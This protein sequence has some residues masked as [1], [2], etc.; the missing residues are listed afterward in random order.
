MKETYEWIEK[1]QGIIFD[2]DGVLIDSGNDITAAVNAL[3]EKLNLRALSKEQVISFVGNGAKKLLERSFTAAF[4]AEGKIPE[5]PA[6]YR[7]GSSYFAKLF[8][9][10]VAYYEANCVQETV[11]YPKTADLLK[12]LQEKGITLGIVSNKPLPVSLAILEKLQIAAYFSAVI[13]PEQLNRIKPDP[14]GIFLAYSYMN[15]K[16]SQEQK[17]PLVPDQIIM[18]GDSKTDILAGKAFGCYTCAVTGGLGNTQEL[19]S[20][21]ADITLQHIGDLLS[22]L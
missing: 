13:G 10:Y 7:D 17:K 4:E 3:L 22:L 2:F 5:N 1:I 14:E 6:A 16:R 9:W 8:A 21:P 12:K 15:E 19:L 11:L 20:L 18:A